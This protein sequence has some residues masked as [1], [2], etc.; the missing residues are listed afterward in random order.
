MLPKHD[1]PEVQRHRTA[2]RRRDLSLPLKCLLRDD[3]LDASA[4]LCKKK[5]MI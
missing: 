2:I 1:E 5:F 4:S 3:L